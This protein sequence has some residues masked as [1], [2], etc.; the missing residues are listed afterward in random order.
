MAAG[1]NAFAW[2]P[3]A[4]FLEAAAA[5]T[6]A[7]LAAEILFLPQTSNRWAICGAMGCFH[8]LFLAGFLLSAQM[9]P[10]YVIPGTLT[11][12]A[13]LAASLGALR[14]RFASGRAE[15]LLAVLLLAS[16]LGWFGLRLIG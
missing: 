12:E 5:L 11:G 4:R 16:G 13:A 9:A 3:P 6:V 7:Y 2:A 14:L 10:G 15:H 1:G 8:G